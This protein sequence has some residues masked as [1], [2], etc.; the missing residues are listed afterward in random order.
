[1]NKKPKHPLIS[2]IEEIPIIAIKGF[3][4]WLPIGLLLE[5]I[6]VDLLAGT[7]IYSHFYEYVGAI[8]AVGLSLH[9][10]FWR[11]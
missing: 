3:V 6:G 9:Y 1:M 7:T 11:T 8:F 4:A 5:I 10:F 2:F